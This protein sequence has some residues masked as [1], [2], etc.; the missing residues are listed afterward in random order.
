MTN[1][2]TLI[3]RI[4]VYEASPRRVD[5]RRRLAMIAAAF[6]LLARITRQGRYHHSAAVGLG[7][8]KPSAPWSKPPSNFDDNNKRL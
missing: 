5:A 2:R 3:L 6:V 7:Q 4:S 1:L 8:Q